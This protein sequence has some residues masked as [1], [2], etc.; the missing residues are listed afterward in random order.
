M[1]LIFT[2]LAWVCGILSVAFFESQIY[3]R[4]AE[5]YRTMLL[6]GILGAFMFGYFFGFIKIG[7]A[8]LVST[9][10]RVSRCLRGALVDSLTLRISEDLAS[11]Q[12]SQESGVK[13]EKKNYRM[14]TRVK[15]KQ[16][17]NNVADADISL[18]EP[19]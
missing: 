3:E 1:L 13:K 11:S 15:E 9:N 14:Q 8:A 12:I 19:E 7:L 2:F 6:Y 18:K 4:R 10:C 16:S 17:S 5:D